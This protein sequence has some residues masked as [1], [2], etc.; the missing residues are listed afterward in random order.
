[1]KEQKINLPESHADITLGQ[2]Q[3]YSKLRKREM[4][5]REFD[6]RKIMIF[7]KLTYKETERVEIED[8]LTLLKF[9]D[10]AME[11][12][13]KFENEFELN[14]VRF[15]F[16]PNLDEIQAKEFFDLKMYKDEDEN[17]H[18][19]MAVLFR[20]ITNTDAYGNYLIEDYNGT[21]KYAETMKGL[22]MNLVFNAIFFFK[23]LR[24]ELSNHI[25]Q[26]IEVEHQKV[27]GRK[28]SSKNGGG[29][30]RFMNWRKAKR[31]V[32]SS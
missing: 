9:I 10:D 7:T 2:F 31:G 28:T 22:P 17:L 6:R 11:T 26:Y 20:P 21:Q 5:K 13:A 25:L 8:Y 1:M 4:P 27:E 15:G 3:R 19:I 23:N 16:I 24:D 12:D 18:K 32:S 29:M 14:G 30:L